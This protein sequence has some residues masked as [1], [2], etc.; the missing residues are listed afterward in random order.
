MIHTVAKANIDIDTNIEDGMRIAQKLSGEVPE[1]ADDASKII[2]H[3]F[4]R[5][6]QRTLRRHGNVVTGTAINSFKT[7][8][9]GQGATGV[10]GVDY[11]E[12]LDKG[13]AAHWPDTNNYRFM[14]AAKSYG[15]DRQQLARVIAR[16]GTKPHP[17]IAR[18]SKKIRKSAKDRANIKMKE[19]LQESLGSF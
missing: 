6:S 18:S 19:A 10:L 5:E 1:K 11:L 7:R 13:T 2:A 8:D 15:M 9:M 17:W 4:I 14:E 12:D 3:S 16:K